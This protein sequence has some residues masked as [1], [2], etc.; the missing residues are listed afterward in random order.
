LSSIESIRAHYKLRPSSPADARAIAALLVEAGLHPV[1]RPDVEQW[2]YWQADCGWTG[3]RSFV[4]TAGEAVIAHGAIVGGALLSERE[5]NSIVMVVDWAARPD[6]AGAG[7]TLMKLLRQNADG[8]LAIGG[9]VHTR[10]ILPHL[11]FKPC[12]EVTS[13]VRPLRPLRLLRGRARGWRLVPRLARSIWWMLRA[14]ARGHDAFTVR[15]ISAETLSELRPVL[16]AP[17]PEF[18]VFERNETSLRHALKCPLVP[19]ELYAL[20]R[21]GA[22]Q[23]YF[24]LAI[25][26]LQA[27]LADCWM[28][29]S[30]PAD[31]RALVQCAVQRARRHPRV[32]E[33]IAWA[34]DPL[35]DRALSECGFHARGTQ[36][37][38]ILMR[39]GRA[40]PA[41]R[42]RV[43]MLE[44]D[45]AYL[46]PGGGSLLA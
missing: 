42:L 12:G 34:S 41:G 9:S 36:P 19:M 39:A 46:E 14:P 1:A 4:L 8:M 18:A 7:I 31:W 2:K 15:R 25:A 20:E 13:Y 37:V 26:G 11:G 29:S 27:R 30:D 6:A 28:T 45:A 23:G 21:S 43:Q 33:T 35:L 44:G 3:D 10:R 24:L 22:L 16:P 17:S 5:R 38:S 40:A 32:A